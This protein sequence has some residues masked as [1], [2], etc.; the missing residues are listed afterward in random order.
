MSMVRGEFPHSRRLIFTEKGEKVRG[1]SLKAI[2]VDRRRGQE[3]SPSKTAEELLVYLESEGVRV[4]LRAR[5]SKVVFEVV[6]DKKRMASL[7]LRG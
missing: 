7:Y 5:T 4:L 2:E 3:R 1:M 6:L